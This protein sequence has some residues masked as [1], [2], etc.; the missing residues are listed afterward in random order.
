M[1]SAW[2]LYKWDFTSAQESCLP[3]PLVTVQ[4]TQPS[5]SHWV[6]L[7]PEG[8]N[9][10]NR[11]ILTR[12]SMLQIDDWFC[13]CIIWAQVKRWFA[14]LTDQVRGNNARQACYT[15]KY[16]E[17][18]LRVPGTGPKLPPPAELQQLSQRGWRYWVWMNHFPFFHCMVL[19]KAVTS[20]PDERANW[21]EPVDVV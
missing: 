17:G 6:S 4:S 15:W 9:G 21:K 20:K 13:E 18:A 11:L 2:C 1:R 7:K 14:L 16:S 3:L 10:R 8:T 5:Q 19:S 12:H